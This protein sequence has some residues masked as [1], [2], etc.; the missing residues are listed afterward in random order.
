MKDG[1]YAYASQQIRSGKAGLSLYEKEEWY[2][3]PSGSAT[4]RPAG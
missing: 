2:S 3:V 1:M 4:Y